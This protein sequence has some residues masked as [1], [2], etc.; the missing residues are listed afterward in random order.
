PAGEY[1]GGAYAAGEDAG[2]FIVGPGPLA[3]PVHPNGD[4][5]NGGGGGNKH[6]ARCTSYIQARNS[7]DSTNRVGSIRSMDR[8]G[9]IRTDNSRIRMGNSRIRSRF[10]WKSEHQNAARERKPIHFPPI[11]S[12]KAFS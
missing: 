12:R 7:S 2:R 8:V 3:A 5:N 11:Q 1:V 10:R 9:S 4:G 6:D